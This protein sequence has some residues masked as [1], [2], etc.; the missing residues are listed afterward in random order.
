MGRYSCIMSLKLRAPLHGVAREVGR[1][2]TRYYLARTR[3]RAARIHGPPQG[4]DRE[5]GPWGFALWRLRVFHGPRRHFLLHVIGY[6]HR[7]HELQ[8]A[9]QGA[10]QESASQEDGQS[11]PQRCY[12]GTIWP[13]QQ[14]LLVGAGRE[15][16]GA[17]P[18]HPVW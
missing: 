1:V 11:G 3:P 6:Y 13:R 12:S 17:A 7:D 5:I 9:G 4:V 18:D 10:E 15:G 16:G 2:R 8:G 14:A